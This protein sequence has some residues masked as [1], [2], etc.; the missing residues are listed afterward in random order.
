MPITDADADILIPVWSAITDAPQQPWAGARTILYTYVL[1]G[2]IGN[3][4]VNAATRNAKASLGS[5]LLEVQ[6][7][8]RLA[9]HDSSI[10]AEML[11]QMNQFCIPASSSAANNISLDRY[12]FSLSKDYLN[13]FR[14]LLRKYPKIK[15]RLHGVGPF[16]VATHKPI[17]ELL[18]NHGKASPGSP[19]LLMDLS[20]QEPKSI[21]G[22]VSSYKE[23]VRKDFSETGEI[24]S[25]RSRIASFLLKVGLSIS[26]V[27]EIYPHA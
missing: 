2:D 20:G 9:P 14:M 7:G 27:L 13:A 1:V 25:L 22:Y 21:S 19:I 16:L 6:A 17:N 3:G 11:A 4:D 18:A 10:S 15:K 26:A 12:N 23:A 5:L 8:Q 24:G